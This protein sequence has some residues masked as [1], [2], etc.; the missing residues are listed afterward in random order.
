MT[1]DDK[2]NPSIQHNYPVQRLVSKSQMWES[3]RPSPRRKEPMEKL[4][5]LLLAGILVVLIIIAFRPR[6]EVGR[7]VSA[8]DVPE[9]LLDT[10]TGQ[11]CEVKQSQGALPHCDSH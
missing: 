8:Q 10:T 5:I 6:R 4:K 1:S 3:V 7:F 9:I 2:V 11:L